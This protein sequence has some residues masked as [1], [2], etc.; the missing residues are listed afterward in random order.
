MQDLKWFLICLLPKKQLSHL[1][2]WLAQVRIPK[3]LRSSL[4]GLFGR[5]FGVNFSEIELPLD[6]Y[7]SWDDFFTRQLK[8][9]LR[10]IADDLLVHPADSVLTVASEINNDNLM[11]VKGIFYSARQLLGGQEK[12][13]SVHGGLALTYYLSPKDYHRV[14]MPCDGKLVEITK[15]D[16][17][18]D[19][20]NALALAKKVGVLA[21]NARWVFEF[22]SGTQG[23]FFV[24]MVGALNVSSITSTLVAGAFVKKGDELG[25]FH[26]GSTVVL[27]FSPGWN[28]Q[29][30]QHLPLAS[31]ELHRPVRFG[32]SLRES[33]PPDQRTH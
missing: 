19:P 27:V 14:H 31:L 29:L 25:Q 28:T 21:T 11:Q 3:F 10:P 26:L 20:V 22:S 30:A 18:Y 33:Q 16:G 9:G 1:V 5:R 15:I 4:W 32:Q 8:A 17:Q 12:Y 13:A 24:V 2:G 6:C 23:G 7:Q